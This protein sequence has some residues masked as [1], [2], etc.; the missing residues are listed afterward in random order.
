[1]KTWA[2]AAGATLIV[3]IALMAALRRPGDTPAER[4]PRPE[5]DVE[6]RLSQDDALTP[7]AA[8]A[9]STEWR[10][11]EHLIDNIRRGRDPVAK[12]L[13]PES[14]Q[15]EEMR[16][17]LDE[18]R[19]AAEARHEELRKRA[20]ERSEKAKREAQENAR[21]MNWPGRPTP[22]PLFTPEPLPEPVTGAKDP[23]DPR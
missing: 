16:R 9:P 3:G 22:S 10:A 11:Y 2:A 17:R 8:D 7:P 18:R 13:L 15:R 6:R 5:V 12:G 21:K 20:T 14:L 23:R 19:K 1:M 4:S